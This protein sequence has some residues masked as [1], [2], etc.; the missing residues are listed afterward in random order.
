MLHQD[1]YFVVSV[2]LNFCLRQTHCIDDQDKFQSVADTDNEFTECKTPTKK[3][4]SIDISPVSSDI[5]YKVDLDP[6]I[7]KKWTMTIRKSGP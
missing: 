6:N 2:K 1:N 4:Q 5:L 3:I 7:Q